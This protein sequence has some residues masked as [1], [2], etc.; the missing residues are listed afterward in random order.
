MQYNYTHVGGGIDYESGPYRVTFNAGVAEIAIDVSIHN[1]NI[2][3]GNENFS[4]TINESSLR[5]RVTVGDSGNVT[6]IIV[7]DDGK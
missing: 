4:L 6:V 1:D 5:S 2:L 3:E 7:D